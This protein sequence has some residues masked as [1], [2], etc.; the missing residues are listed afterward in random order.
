MSYEF[1]SDEEECKT[2]LLLTKIPTHG[3]LSWLWVYRDYL[4]LCLPG[5]VWELFPDV[6]VFSCISFKSWKTFLLWEKLQFASRFMND[7]FDLLIRIV[8]RLL[9]MPRV[10]D[11]VWG[12]VYFQSLRRSIVVSVNILHL[13]CIC[14]SGFTQDVW[15]W[16]E[17]RKSPI[18]E[19]YFVPMLLRCW[20]FVW[21]YWIRS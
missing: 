7:I 13:N 10:L 21:L 20:N 5:N 8:F 18:W 12:V 2:L 1:Q 6:Y 19:A 17:Q 4:E 9:Y 16:F 11:D 15:Y 3:K 14:A